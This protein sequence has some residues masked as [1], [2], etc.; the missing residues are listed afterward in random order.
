LFR[1]KAGGV[2]ELGVGSLYQR[3]FGTCSIAEV[4]LAYFASYGFHIGGLAA[5]LELAGTPAGTLG[6]IGVQENFDLRLGKYH[7]ADI[8][9][10]HHNASSFRQAAL[11]GKQRTPHAGH[12]RN[13]GSGGGDTG[14]ANRF[15]DIFAVEQDTAFERQ[16]NI[17]LLRQPFEPVHIAGGDA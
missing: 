12:G 17:G 7:R 11:Y 3:R 15:G 4:A 5:L 6:R 13:L 16:G 10:F 8:A 1:R 14:V 9:T 2:D